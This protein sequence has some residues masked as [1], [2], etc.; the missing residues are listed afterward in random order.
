MQRV[1]E[2]TEKHGKP[3]VASITPRRAAATA[4]ARAVVALLRHPATARQA[5]LASLVLSL[6]KAMEG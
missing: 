5:V 4:D 2:Q 3:L 6:P 1:D